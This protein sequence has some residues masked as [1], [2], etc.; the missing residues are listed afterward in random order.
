MHPFQ[1][2]VGPDVLDQPLPGDEPAMMTCLDGYPMAQKGE[3]ARAF[4]A[5]Y[6]VSAMGGIFGALVLI[7]DIWAI[8]NVVQSRSETGPKVLWIA[9]IILLFLFIDPF[10][11]VPFFVSALKDVDPARRRRVV[12]R[13][14][15]IAYLVMV[16][17]LFVG[18]P[19]LR[20]L[21][22]SGPALTIAGGVILFLIALKMVFPMQRSAHAAEELQGEPLLVPLAIPMVAGPSAMA[23]VMLL[24][25]DNPD[26]MP[27]WVLALFLAWLLTSLILLSAN[28]RPS[29]PDAALNCDRLDGLDLA[30]R[31]ATVRESE[32]ALYLNGIERAGVVVDALLGTGVSGILREPVRTAVDVVV[33]AREAQVPV[34]A[35]DTP[36]AV[37]LTTGEPSNPV[38][39][40]DVTITF[41]RPKDGLRARIG[42]LLAGA[43]DAIFTDASVSE[44]FQGE[45]L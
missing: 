41:H 23:V 21:G 5:A 26:R 10:G 43:I 35:V 18:G 14:L 17:F 22:I 39:R 11:N 1:E 19:F 9:A 2:E 16:M 37:D 8:L 42:K 34:L 12:I 38:V 7:A 44:I 45:N 31:V 13:E 4:G 29:T 28:G 3:A 24:A 15:L 33:R 30:H 36:T 6:T 40:A 25:S 27:E 32:V 20:V